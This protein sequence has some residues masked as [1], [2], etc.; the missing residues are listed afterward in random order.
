[1]DPNSTLAAA[2]AAADAARAWLAAADNSA[3]SARYKDFGEEVTDADI[4]VQQ[5]I[6]QTL[7]ERFP[8]IPV[9]GE[10][11]TA[12]ERPGAAYWLVDPIDG[13]INFARR[14]PYFAVS[15]ALVEDGV[16][17]F[18][19][20]DMPR[21]G[22]RTSSAQPTPEPTSSPA[23]S[24]S[25]ALVGV[26]GT[27]PSSKAIL[28]GDE[29]VATI[30]ASS[31]RMRMS[32]SMCLDLASVAEGWLDACV[33]HRPKPWDVAAGLAIVRARGLSAIGLDGTDFAV[34]EPLLIA[35]HHALAHEIRSVI[36][37]L[38]QRVK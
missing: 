24:L 20:I 17:T 37:P 7:L 11:S 8:T 32:G 12:G 22:V 35:A 29:L 38:S 21:F 16:P 34:G 36:A 6:A 2:S 15:I 19:L 9:V 10:E 30:H 4:E 13:T 33:C 31:Y 1:M 23:T 3:F 5:A 28:N 25:A 26:T 14:S 18:G 27:S